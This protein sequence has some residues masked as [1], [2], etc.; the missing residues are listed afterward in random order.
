MSLGS[1]GDADRVV[2]GG[3]WANPSQN[4][5]A[6]YRNRNEARIRNRF[7]GFRVVFRAGPEHASSSQ[8]EDWSRAGRV[9][10]RPAVLAGRPKPCCPTVPVSRVAQRPEIGSST[11]RSTTSSPHIST[12]PSSTVLLPACRDGAATEP[13][14]GFWSCN[15]AGVM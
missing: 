2:R 12:A 1:S 15:A 5:R 11:G 13:S 6:A 9:L 3:S 8:Q 4:L 14:S 10:D 7:L